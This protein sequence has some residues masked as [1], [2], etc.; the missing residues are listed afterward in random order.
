[1]RELCESSG[2]KCTSLLLAVNLD[3]AS[4]HVMFDGSLLPH[5]D[6]K[7]YLLPCLCVFS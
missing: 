3:N 7:N 5:Y 6:G 4:F 1:M 2:G